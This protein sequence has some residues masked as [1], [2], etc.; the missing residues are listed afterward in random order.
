MDAVM[1]KADVLY[2]ALPVFIILAGAY[3][4]LIM[5]YIVRTG[6]PVHDMQE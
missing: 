1:Q 2:L 4:L 3:Y 6:T 5:L